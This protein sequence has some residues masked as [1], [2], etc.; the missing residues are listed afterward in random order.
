MALTEE[1]IRSITPGALLWIQLTDAT[2]APASP[3]QVCYV[4]DVRWS[5][6]NIEQSTFVVRPRDAPFFCPAR[7]LGYGALRDNARLNVHAH[8]FSSRRVD[9]EP[10]C[11]PIAVPSMGCA[12]ETPIGRSLCDAPPKTPPPNSSPSGDLGWQIIAQQQQRDLEYYRGLLDEIGVAFGDDAFTTDAGERVDTVL[13]AKLPEIA[14]ERQA[15][16]DAAVVTEG[17]SFNISFEPIPLVDLSAERKRQRR[18]KYTN[19]GIGVAVGIGLSA[20]ILRFI[21]MFL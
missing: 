3:E 18:E 13:R 19:I 8:S 20:V 2:G 7:V 1:E 11:D 14:R 15:L 10:T 6:Q 4:L 17:I 5:S 16:M 12:V 21:S 9:G